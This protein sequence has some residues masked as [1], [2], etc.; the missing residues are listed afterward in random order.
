MSVGRL[1]DGIPTPYA[2]TVQDNGETVFCGPLLLPLG[3]PFSSITYTSRP[4]HHGQWVRFTV[5]LTPVHLSPF[6]DTVDITELLYC[7][8]K[9]GL[10]Q[11]VCCRS[12]KEL[13]AFRAVNLLGVRLAVTR[14]GRRSA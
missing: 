4:L 5:R 9:I 3:D 6:M 14:H 12:E 8:H 2:C 10:L 1:G 13:L 11:R 7:G